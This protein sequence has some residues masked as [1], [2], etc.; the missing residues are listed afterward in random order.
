VKLSFM[1]KPFKPWRRCTKCNEMR[2]KEEFA[3]DVRYKDA[4]TSHCRYCRS[5]H[6]STR[7]LQK[8]CAGHGAEN[9]ARRRLEELRDLKELELLP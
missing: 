6:N 1:G 3:D 5:T 9:A 4:K 2:A 8:T 7:F